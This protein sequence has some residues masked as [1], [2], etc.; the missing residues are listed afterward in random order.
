MPTVTL[1]KTAVQVLHEYCQKRMIDLQIKVS[2]HPR[3]QGS[4][5]FPIKMNFWHLYC[6]NFIRKFMVF[7]S[8][9]GNLAHCLLNNGHMRAIIGF[10]YFGRLLG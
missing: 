7:I 8:R 6:S 10:L 2:D 3:P 9:I 4:V 5:F 1:E